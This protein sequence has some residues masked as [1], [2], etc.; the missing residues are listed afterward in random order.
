MNLSVPCASAASVTL[1]AERRAGRKAWPGPTV[2]G[3]QAASPSRPQRSCRR[4]EQASWPR[5]L[6]AIRKKT[7]T[8]RSCGR[9]KHRPGPVRMPVPSG[10]PFG[11]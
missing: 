7:R 8:A 2:P 5:P 11:V 6:P 4:A 10:F 9:P 1:P 3:R